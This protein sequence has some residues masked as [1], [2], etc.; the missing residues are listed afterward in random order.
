MASSLFTI[1]L[2]PPRSISEIGVFKV[3]S[4]FWPSTINFV[5][6]VKYIWS[7][8]TF[9]VC[10]SLLISLFP[11]TFNV[12]LVEINFSQFITFVVSRELKG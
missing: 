12:S 6:C 10:S 11:F 3:T 2:L 5:S 7:I 4:I 9:P 8:T 1:A